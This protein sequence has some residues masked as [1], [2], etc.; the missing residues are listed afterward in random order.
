MAEP[1]PARKAPFAIEVVAGRHYP[2]CA[3]GRSARQPFCDGSHERFGLLPMTF[4]VAEPGT[5][6]FRGCKSTKN[7]PQCDGTHKT[8]S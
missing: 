6:W 1:I 5:V 2:W 8:L 7:R 4:A 3:R